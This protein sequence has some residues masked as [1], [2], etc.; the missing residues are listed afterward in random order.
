VIH[1]FNLYS[2]RY[3]CAFRMLSLRSI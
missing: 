3:I 1:V 2:P